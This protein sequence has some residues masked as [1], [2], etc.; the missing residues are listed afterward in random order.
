VGQRRGCRGFFPEQDFLEDC[1]QLPAIALPGELA[2]GFASLF[3]KTFALSGIVEELL[4]HFGQ[5]VSIRRVGEDQAVTAMSDDFT[6][7]IVGR[8][9][10]RF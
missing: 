6:G 1:S 3:A 8:N 4:N 5:R 2:R 10:Y 7:A 9:D